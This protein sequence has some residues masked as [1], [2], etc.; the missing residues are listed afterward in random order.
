MLKHFF[1][2]QTFINHLSW[3]EHS[4]LC[5]EYSGKED[6]AE[7]QEGPWKQTNN[8]IIAVASS[9]IGVSSECY[10]STGD[11]GKGDG[12]QEGLGKGQGCESKDEWV[13]GQ[14]W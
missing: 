4:A 14:G 3:S 11:S 5:W 10:K 12:V 2:Q 6:P 13:N 8:Y 7:P 1:I 9:I